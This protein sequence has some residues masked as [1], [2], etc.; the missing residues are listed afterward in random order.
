MD[1]GIG[2]GLII[3]AVTS[4]SIYIWNSEHFTKSQK[5]FLLICIIFPPAQ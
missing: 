4:S 1:E 5:T 2:V 3:G